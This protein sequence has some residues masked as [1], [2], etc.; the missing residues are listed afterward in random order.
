MFSAFCKNLQTSLGHILVKHYSASNDA[1]VT[2][3]EE[4]NHYENSIYAQTHAQDIHENLTNL[5]IATWKGTFQAFLNHWE[6]QW[7]L[8]DKSTVL[9]NQESPPVC[10]SMLCNAIHSNPDFLQVKHLDKLSQTQGSSKVPYHSYLLLLCTTA[11]QVNFKRPK[12]STHQTEV[13]STHSTSNN[14]NK[15]SGHNGKG[16]S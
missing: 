1:Q 8:I 9:C 15:S 11:F 12:H 3:T 14:N 13:N 10:K 7:L 6:S 4:H 16:H 5:C 2:A